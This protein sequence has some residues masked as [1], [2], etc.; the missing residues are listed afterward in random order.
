MQAGIEAGAGHF[1]VALGRHRD[2]RGLRAG[3]RLPP[4]GQRRA[5]DLRRH[6]L[7]ARAIGIGDADQLDSGQARELLRVQAPHV[8][9]A[10]DR[11]LQ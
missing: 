4:V 1:E 7:G 8:A 3:H 11:H 2:H 6:F 10:D 9:G 5:A